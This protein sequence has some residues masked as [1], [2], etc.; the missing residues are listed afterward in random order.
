[1]NQISWVKYH[2][3]D[4]ELSPALNTFY[5][6]QLANISDLNA[7]MKKIRRIQA[8]ANIIHTVVN[9]PNL[10]GKVFTGIVLEKGEDSRNTIYI[11]ELKW[12]TQCKLPDTNLKLYDTVKCKLFV[13]DN[14]EKM[15]K[16]IR[17]QL[18]G[19]EAP[20]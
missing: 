17:I 18:E 19:G 8:D 9:D 20:L 12:V 11:D 3:K 5:T 2:L 16:K 4:V 6:S 13:F 1:M 10:L 7:K 15:R 14:E